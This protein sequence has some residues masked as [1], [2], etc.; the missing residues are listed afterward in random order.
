MKKI[1]L[2]LAI[3]GL[4]M[5][6]GG[7]GSERSLTNSHGTINS[8]IVVL[9]NEDWGGTLGDEI[10]EIF[11]AQVD[12]VINEEPIF[13]LK[14]LPKEVF[15]G[16]VT[17]NRNILV[18]DKGD[19]KQKSFAIKQNVY[20]KPQKI[21]YVTGRTDQEI[22]ESL[23]ENAV[24]SVALIHQNELYEKQRQIKASLNKEKGLQEKL[25]VTLRM[26]SIYKTVRKEDNFLWIERALPNGTMNLMAYEVPT[27]KI[28]KDSLR[29]A[30]FVTLRD[31][32]GARYVPGRKKGSHMITEM[33]FAPSMAS[34]TIDGKYA[35]EARGRWELK[36]DFMAGPFITY[37]VDDNANNRQIVLEGFVFAPQKDKR[38]YLFELE[39]IIKSL[40]V[41]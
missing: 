28:P 4:L 32:I 11:A 13:S 6:C 41:L 15:N 27:D 12:G 31:S 3:S 23:Q 17:G 7:E 20:S 34:T 37:V 29:M 36:N 19:D 33:M 40:R 30:S 18:V 1:F 8:L 2:I 10:R 21:F 5:T 9:D 38:D 24:K 26:P 39:A 14:Q 35:L 16:F 25:G 22:I